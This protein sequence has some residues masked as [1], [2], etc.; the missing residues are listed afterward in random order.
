M[1]LRGGLDSF[2]WLKDRIKRPRYVVDLG[3]IAEL[4]GIRE[5]DGGLE[6]GAM[7]TLTD[8]VRH[9]MVRE[10]YAILTEAAEAAASPQIRNQGRSAATSRRTR[11][12]GTTAPAGRAIEPAETSATPTRRNRSTGS[13]PFSRRIDAL[14]SILPIPRLR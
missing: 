1:D 2:D 11:A 14:R 10:R 12:A 4:K 3:G 9:P 8:V 6:I 5:R 7:T 13:T